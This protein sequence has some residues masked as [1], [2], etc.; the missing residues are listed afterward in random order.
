MNEDTLSPPSALPPTH[1]M[2]THL[3]TADTVLSLGYLTLSSR[4]LLL[5]LLGGSVAA[6]VWTRTAGLSTVLPPA[7]A[8]LHWLLLI[9][10]SLLILA[11]TFGAIAGRSL[12]AWV[13]VLLAYRARPRRYLWRSLRETPLP[14]PD[15]EDAA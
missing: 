8:A 12:D 9:G 10:L 7:G 2:P 1:T 6:S 11:L 3:A 13:M 14:D 15:Q 4:Q 5:L